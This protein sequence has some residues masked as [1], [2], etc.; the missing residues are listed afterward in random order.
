MGDAGDQA[1][2][3]REPFGFDEIAL[4]FAGVQSSLG[5]P[6]LV[7]DFGKQRSKN[8]CAERHKENAQLGRHHSLVDWKIRI[9]EIADAK[10]GRPND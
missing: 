10:S 9:A 1:A 5:Q 3:C 8:R 7:A 6:P 4:C 2:E